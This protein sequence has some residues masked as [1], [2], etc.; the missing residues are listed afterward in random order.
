M[1][2]AAATSPWQVPQQ[3]QQHDDRGSQSL[4]DILQQQ[5]VAKEEQQQQLGSEGLLSPHAGESM[6]GQGA[7]V[8]LS[9]WSSRRNQVTLRIRRDR[10]LARV[11]RETYLRQDFHFGLPAA[12]TQRLQREQLQHFLVPDAEV[13]LN[14][15][16]VFEL[17]ALKG[18]VLLSSRMLA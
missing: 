6:L 5:D 12:A 13:L 17:A 11:L 9:R 3:Q 16:E 7:A 4:D 1:A 14:Y 8:P 15:L 2:W 10:S 18:R